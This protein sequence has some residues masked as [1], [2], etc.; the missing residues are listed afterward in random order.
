MKV[1]TRRGCSPYYPSMDN[2]YAVEK[3][4][5]F[6]TQVKDHLAH[7]EAHLEQPDQDVRLEWHQELALNMPLMRGLVTAYLPHA[8]NEIDQYDDRTTHYWRLVRDAVAQALGHARSADE[9]AVFLRPTS[10]SIAAD[11]LHPWVWGSAAQP[12]K[13]DAYQDAVVAA[14]RTLARRLQQ[15]V[16]RHDVGDKELCQQSFAVTDPTPGKPRLR[17]DGD[18]TTATWKARQDGAMHISA[19]AVTGIRNVAAHEEKVP[20]TEQ[21]ALEYLATLSVVARW[22]EECSVETAP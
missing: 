19:G 6:L 3:L 17:F 1:R 20:W 5:G 4:T 21:E 13:A 15:K 8:L 22:I 12:W 7:L 2:A 10:P 16:G 11:A 9:L 18:R 14:C